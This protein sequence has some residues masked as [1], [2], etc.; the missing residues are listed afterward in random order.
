MKSSYILAAFICLPF[1]FNL[2]AQTFDCIPPTFIKLFGRFNGGEMGTVM[3]LGPDNHLYLAGAIGGGMFIQKTTTSGKAVWHRQFTYGATKNVKIIEISFDSEGMLIGCGTQSFGSGGAS[4]GY[5]FRYQPE[6]DTFLWARNYD[7]NQPFVAGM[8]EKFPGGNFLL[9]QNPNMGFDIM[10]NDFEIELLELDRQTGEIIPGFAKRYRHL[11]LDAISKMV[12]VNGALYGA[13]SVTW[14]NL[15]PKARRLFLTRFNPDNGMPIWS[16][17]YNRDTFSTSDFTV[18]DLDVDGNSLIATYAMSENVLAGADYFICLQKTDLDGHIQWARQYYLDSWQFVQLLVVPDG[19]ILFSENLSLAFKF[20]FKIDKN[21]QLLWARRLNLGN[22]NGVNALYLG[23][24]RLAAVADSLYVTGTLSP[25]PSFSNDLE[26][27]LWKIYANGGMQDSCGPVTAINFDVEEEQNPVSIPFEFE[28]GPS[29]AVSESAKTPLTTSI[30]TEQ[31]LCP[32][33]APMSVACPQVPQVTAATGANQ[34]T[35][36]FELPN[37]ASNCYCQEF[38]YE[39][40]EGMAPGSSFPIGVTQVCYRVSDECGSSSS[41]CFEV[42][43]LESEEV[44]DT[45]KIGCMTYELLSIQQD[46]AQH[47]TYRLRITNDCQQKLLYTAIQLPDGAVAEL[48]SNFSNYFS[49][50]GFSYSI[51]NPNYSPFYS[52]RFKSNGSGIS[53]GAADVLEYTL[54]PQY[55]PDYIHIASRL[56]Q[57]LFFESHLNTFYCPTI[58]ADRSVKPQSPHSMD[59]IAIPNPAHVSEPVSIQLARPSV[60]AWFV[61]NSLGQ[62]IFEGNQPQNTLEIPPYILAAAGIYHIVL[63]DGLKPVTVKLVVL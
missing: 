29:P 37:A 63:L 44:C 27:M 60:D 9:Y 28:T 18:R 17:Y 46:A 22:W 31:Y 5:A 45:K 32:Q 33:Y 14:N 4:R 10:F 21:G 24:N 2:V 30:L 38:N 11:F 19:Y 40:Y 55:E 34:A 1:G 39:L 20:I 58:A 8:L 57:Q 62:V 3:T 50:N 48:P 49:D 53:A 13:G 25:R 36:N 61:A 16:N 6:A 12:T 7:S 41:C 56:E 52:I 59:A 23:P 15:N 43:V 26:I 51:N 54:P 47:R 42:S 35:V